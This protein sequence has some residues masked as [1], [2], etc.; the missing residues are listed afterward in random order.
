MASIGVSPRNSPFDSDR[1]G[2]GH[3]KDLP[4]LS[5]S[6]TPNGHSPAEPMDLSP[7]AAG[8]RDTQ[9]SNSPSS[10]RHALHSSNVSEKDQTNGS[11]GPVGAAAAAQQPKV[12]QTAFIHKLYRWVWSSD[13]PELC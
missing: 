13:W 3:V 2:R 9:V 4:I 7:S 8:F 11:Y 5:A 12:V 10:D 6:A 1:L